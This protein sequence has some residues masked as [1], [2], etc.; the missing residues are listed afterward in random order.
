MSASMFDA[1]EF[2]PNVGSDFKSDPS[3]TLLLAERDEYGGPM[4][5][6]ESSDGSEHS[7]QV[8]VAY[9]LA[10]THAGHLLH[11]YGI[12]WHFWDGTRWAF[13]DTGAA[14]RAVLD[15]LRDALAE[16]LTDKRLRS[17]VSKCESH[18]GVQ[19]VLGIASALPQFSVT[20]RDLDAD[21]YLLNVAN[22]TLDLRT[23]ELSPHDPANRI[24]KVTRAA[25]HPG[26][27]GTGEWQRFLATVLPDESVRAYVQ[28]QIGVA[29]LGRVTEHVLSIWTGT[30]A[31]GKGTAIGGLCWALGDYASTAEPE[32]LLHRNGA[33][34]TG[35]MDLMGR[36][37][38]VMSETD[39]SRRMAEATMKRLTGGDIIRARRMRQDFIEFEPSHTAIL[40]TNHLPGVSGDD[41]AVW[42]RIRVVPFDVVI[43][44]ADR[45]GGLPEK[46]QRATNEILS[47]AITGW[48]Q[49][50]GIGL[51]E[52][53]TVL[54]RTNEYKTDSDVIGQFMADQCVTSSPVM[55]ATTGQLFEAWQQWR[56]RNGAPE[57]SVKAFG[58]ALD[59]HGYPASDAVNGKRWRHGIALTAVDSNG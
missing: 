42:R 16:S 15:V 53:D 36:R 19:G 8:R 47:W 4:P 32:L 6:P 46:L 48:A 13:D 35:E 31:N 5:R 2:S 9:R 25:Y 52:P 26:D 24:T 7:G 21:P 41:P 54:A 30:G 23:M 20:V 34:P 44:E 10:R 12:G 22:G 38:V 40:V 11:V 17:D 51:A 56:V 3:G 29:L 33:H 59:R 39:E 55:K 49:Y 1:P 43:P 27:T 28:R 37:L 45:D 57:I 14:V 50:R 58:K 18:S